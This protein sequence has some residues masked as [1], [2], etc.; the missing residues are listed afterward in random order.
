MVSSK[1][2]PGGNDISTVACTY[3]LKPS[4]PP[5]TCACLASLKPK[6]KAKT[7]TNTRSI[8]LI[9]LPYLSYHFAYEAL[10]LAPWRRLSVYQRSQQTYLRGL[11]STL[12]PMVTKLISCWDM[13]HAR[14]DTLQA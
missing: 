9:N 10:L 3:T 1:I 2:G 5:L 12:C 7:S 4:N 6:V 8:L 14:E 13:N 11:A